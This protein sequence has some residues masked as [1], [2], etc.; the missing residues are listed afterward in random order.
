MN[1]I[2]YY[3]LNRNTLRS[4]WCNQEEYS[5]IVLNITLE[6]VISIFGKLTR[7]RYHYR[8]SWN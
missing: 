1:Y 8:G 6:Q 2:Y 7:L 4:S 5:S 3:K